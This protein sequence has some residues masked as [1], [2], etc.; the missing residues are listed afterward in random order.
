MIFFAPAIVEYM[1]KNLSIVKPCD[2]E[3]ILPVPWPFYILRLH[4]MCFLTKRLASGPKSLLESL[5]PES[6][7]TVLFKF[8]YCVQV[9]KEETLVAHNHYFSLLP[10]HISKIMILP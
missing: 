2:C 4:C 9:S 7:T 5:K 6:I 8:L 3:H 10:T 1:K